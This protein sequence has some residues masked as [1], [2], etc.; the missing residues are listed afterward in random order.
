MADDNT[1]KGNFADMLDSSFHSLRR[2]E[3][4]EKVRCKLENITEEWIFLNVGRKG[5]G[6][7]DKKELL[8]KEGNC[9]V[10]VGDTIEAY[11]LRSKAGEMVFTTRLGRGENGHEQLEDAFHNQI[12]VEA[13]VEKEIKGGFEC[14]IG[15][16]ARAFCPYSQMALRRVNDNS[17]YIGEHFK[18]YITEFQEKGRNIVLSRRQIL[19]EEE[20]K[21]REELKA[22]LSE[23]M[24]LKGRITNVKP[25]G[26]F[27]DVGGLEGLIPISEIS[28]DHIT[29][30]EEVLSVGQEVEVKIARLDWEQNR[31]SFSLKALQTDP[32]LEV[33]DSF[34]VGSVV[35][36]TV[37]RLKPFG[38]FVSLG[39][40]IDGLLH[41]SKIA[42]QERVQ[43]PAQVLKVG[44]EI[45]VEIDSIDLETKRIS[46]SQ[47][48][49]NQGVSRE[50]EEA[51]WT[52]DYKKS[53][54]NF[55]GSSSAGMGSLG[56]LLKGALDKKEE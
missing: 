49:Q 38:A 20:E 46:L 28:Y 11:F 9:K 24:V 6:V 10:Q 42:S 37:V 30:I 29:N 34:P 50:E 45:E 13:H 12:P 8:D 27:C 31:H 25:F 51:S 41:V 52:R 19:L 26:A 48:N 16:S 56:A 33:P 15:G 1:T 22:S 14:K 43:Y 39:K 36:G 17:I 35:K 21:A 23:G 5:E 7:L 2:L 55:S 3:P 53:Q 4:G 44:Q 18:F 47:P 40:G 54:S 32:W